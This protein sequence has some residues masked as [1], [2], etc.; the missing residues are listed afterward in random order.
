MDDL[1]EK[2]IN[3]LKPIEKIKNYN[4]MG[5]TY[6]KCLCQC[7]NICYKS[8][9]NL[10]SDKAYSCGCVTRRSMNQRIDYTSQRF[11]HLVI[12]RMLYH[13]KNNQ[14]YAECQCDCG[15]TTIAYMGNIKS[16][17]TCS[18]G[19]GEKASR[20]NRPHHEKNI[21]NERFGKLLV[22]D[23]TDRRSANGSVVWKCQCN[24]GQTTYVDGT[25][26]MSGHTKSCGCRKKE[27]N[28]S[29]KIAVR[30]G[31]HFGF[32]TI[33]SEVA[34]KGHRTF[35]CRCV[36]GKVIDV[37]LADLRSKHTMSCGC[38]H[39]SKGEKYIQ[40]LLEQ[41]NIPFETQKRF[42]EC[43]NKKPLPFDFYLPSYRTCIEYQGEQH[44]RSVKSWRGESG[45]QQRQIND[46]IKRTYCE[47]HKIHLICIPYTLSNED[48]RKYL[49]DI[50]DPVTITA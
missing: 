36:C 15:N 42:S 38:Q 30:P 25:A 35:T 39:F 18:C 32:L 34:S 48:I 1:I 47:S 10:I 21:L 27:Y 7:G 23:K 20:Y 3:L 37:S 29:K 28:D 17:K 43:R 49:L 40:A 12:N 14:T 19:C 13:Y 33:I 22:I 16:G 50:L 2:Q 45:F 26:L 8:R 11:G 46:N 9:S 31:N 24:C 6:Y 4:N 44:Y 5:K 41:W